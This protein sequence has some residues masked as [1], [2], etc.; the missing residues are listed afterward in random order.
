MIEIRIKVD[1][2]GNAKTEM[3][4]Q[5]TAGQFAH[6]IFQTEMLKFKVLRM[7]DDDGVGNMIAIKKD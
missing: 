1:D 4:G 7:L 3:V 5:A 2:D 6:V